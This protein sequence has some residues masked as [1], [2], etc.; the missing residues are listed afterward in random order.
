MRG[1]FR[2]NDD[3]GTPRSS[4]LINYFR[5]FPFSGHGAGGSFPTVH[6]DTPN[7]STASANASANTEVLL[8]MND[9][10]QEDEAAVTTQMAE[11][12][13]Y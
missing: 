5:T 9:D 1:R 7:S 12:R 10:L 6:F 8:N 4:T 11:R 2:K 3:K 13:V